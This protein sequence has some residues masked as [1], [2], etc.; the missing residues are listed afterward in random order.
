MLT[1]KAR[2]QLRKLP[3]SV[4]AAVKAAL[5]QGLQA[6]PINRRRST[7][8]TVRLGAHYR[9]VVERGTD[10]VVW[11]GSHEDYNNYL[12]RI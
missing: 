7:L 1:R 8:A 10:T 4:E 11:V 6:V 9:M 2:K 3:A 5:R 12:K